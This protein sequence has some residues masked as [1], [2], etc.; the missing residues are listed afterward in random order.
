MLRLMILN[1]SYRSPLTFN[2]DVIEQAERALERLRGALRP[3][4]PLSKTPQGV[5]DELTSALT[6]A[7]AGFEQAM[8]DDFNSAGAL[9]HLFD[10]VK[11]INTARTAGIAVEPLENAQG[12]LRK[13]TGVLGLR[14]DQGEQLESDAATRFGVLGGVDG[15]EGAFAE[16][17]GDVV[18]A[19]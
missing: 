1:A 16:V 14:L 15:A 8:D 17:F 11:A 10:L 4:T 6:K 2:D 5:A 3:A 13:L 19:D 7:Q 18:R 9:G 12:L